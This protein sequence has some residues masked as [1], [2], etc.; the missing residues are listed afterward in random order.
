MDGHWR[1]GGQASGE[2]RAGVA[3]GKGG[4]W[5]LA[6]ALNGQTVS[7][8]LRFPQAVH[9]APLGEV[10][11]GRDDAPAAARLPAGQFFGAC[12]RRPPAAFR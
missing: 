2:V 5:A 7:S 1:F 12:D 3:G 11:V 9:G 4:V 8:V 6:S 10:P